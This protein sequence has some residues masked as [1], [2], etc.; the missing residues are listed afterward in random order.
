MKY[1]TPLSG[2]MPAF[3]MNHSLAG[4]AMTMAA[5]LDVS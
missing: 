4:G 1:P 5:K 3:W 2:G